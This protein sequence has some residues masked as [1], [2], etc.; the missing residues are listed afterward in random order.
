[1]I[2]GMRWA[3]ESACGLLTIL[4]TDI[5]LYIFLSFDLVVRI[6]GWVSALESKRR[7]HVPATCACLTIPHR[8]PFQACSSN[9]SHLCKVIFL[10][11]YGDCNKNQILTAYNI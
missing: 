6:S 8:F 7:P 9:S 4:Y 11:Y 2:L 1:M 3:S 5:K 10:R